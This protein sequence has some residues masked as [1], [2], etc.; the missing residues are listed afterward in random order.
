[1]PLR[2]ERFNSDGFLAYSGK[3]QIG[4]IA[5]REDGTHAWE[6]TGVHMKWIAKG[7]G[8]AR[9]LDGAKA[10]VSRGWRT[11]LRRAGLTD[12]G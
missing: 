11:W 3:T 1:M 7:Y 10:A 5:C 8:D 4:M 6:I 2:W 12:G 9:S